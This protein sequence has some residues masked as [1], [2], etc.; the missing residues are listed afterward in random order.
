VR[1][2]TA[3]VNDEE[4]TGEDIQRALPGIKAKY[5]LTSIVLV[6]APV[7]EEEVDDVVNATINPGGSTPH[8]KRIKKHKSQYVERKGRRYQL[9]S[10]YDTKVYIRD[11]FYGKS[12]QPHVYV[13]RDGLV[14]RL[15]SK[16]GL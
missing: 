1:D 6:E 3:L 7:G 5:K 14:N 11:H 12:Y 9:K 10:G 2:A 8:R 13:W 16:G 4:K 15:R